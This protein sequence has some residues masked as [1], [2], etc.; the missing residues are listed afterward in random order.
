[1]TPEQTEEV[2]A[3]AAEP[4]DLELSEVEL[5][6][7]L[8]AVLLVVDE[9]VPS[10]RLAAGLG[11]PEPR[12]LDVLER[13]R[14]ELRERASGIALREIA[15]GWRFYT[16]EEY[17]DAV[18]R[19]LLDGQSA[20][21]SQAALETLA[22]IAYQQPISRARVAAVRGVNVDGVVRTLVVRGLIAER[23]TE[24]GS[25][26]LLY[27]TTPLFLERLGIND[28]AELPPLAPLLPDLGGLADTDVDQRRPQR[29][30]A[31]AEPPA[32]EIDLRE[33]DSAVAAGPDSDE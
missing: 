26:A 31:A 15:G 18:G 23:G 8:E 27:G 6:G 25:G 22:V 14:A 1:M 28:V 24:D 10:A 3:V 2:D 16:A 9:S 33:T 29:A 19:F 13:M 20:R 32:A 30:A 4:V 17:S 12:V 11:V 5:R 7:T 21:L